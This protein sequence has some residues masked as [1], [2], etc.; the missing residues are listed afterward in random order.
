M[1]MKTQERFLQILISCIFVAATLCVINSCI[2]DDDDDGTGII[3]Y[4]QTRVATN[5]GVVH[6]ALDNN[7]TYSWKGIPYAA[8]P[9]DDLRW[10]APQDPQSWSSTLETTEFCEPCLQVR[11]GVIFGSEDC[12]C[13]N[14]WRPQGDQSNLP[15][16]FYIHGGY[17]TFGSANEWYYDGAN[18]AGDHNIVVVT[19]QYRLGILGWLT[20]PALRHDESAYDDSGNFGTLDMIKALI[21]VDDNI[22]EF[23]GDPNNVTIAGES[24]GAIDVVSLLISP[25][26]SGL[27]H[28]GISMGG[29]LGGTTLTKINSVEAGE[30][31]ANALLTVLLAKDGLTEVPG[32]DVEAYLRSKTGEELL[33]L[34]TDPIDIN[35]LSATLSGD[36]KAIFS[37]GTVIHENGAS[38]L[39]DPATYNQV[40]LILGNNAEEHKYFLYPVFDN[41]PMA[42]SYQRSAEIANNFWETWCTNNIA[43]AISGLP[44][45]P[46][47]YTYKFEYGAYHYVYDQAAGDIIP[48]PDGYNAWPTDYNGT[49]YALMLGSAHSLDIAFF[50]G[51]VS[52]N[53]YELPF[54]T[55][56]FNIIVRE[57]N[58]QGAQALSDAMTAYIAEFLYN[59]NPSDAGGVLWEPWSN[60][61]GAPK[62]I[63]FD[64]NDT[65][66]I[67]EMS[68]E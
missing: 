52:I 3:S 35:N 19:I 14:I 38:A 18:L 63:I 24:A 13:L 22:Q 10:K 4:L 12:L 53:S 26:A 17:N 23:G 6:G 60:D 61:P 37:D 44:G 68:Y 9:V 1:I 64:A 66:S 58:L 39:N 59:G 11:N 29:P 56:P 47:V 28:R 5:S 21:W 40:P 33:S 57:D 15:V 55:T 51:D 32:N 65:E 49:N 30:D 16:Y 54:L 25:A 41:Y 46:P 67:I 27:F 36:F 34:Y 8:P 31:H 42:Q 62:R 50:F 45:Q 2:F 7:N 48:D 20:H 43:N